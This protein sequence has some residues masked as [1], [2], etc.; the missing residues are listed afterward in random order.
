MRADDSGTQAEGSGTWAE[1]SGSICWILALENRWLAQ[2]LPGLRL[3]TR[4]CHFEWR[5]DSRG[6]VR[7]TEAA[8]EVVTH[9]R[10][11]EGVLDS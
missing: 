10:S 2:T 7:M 6:E 8:G 3:R 11:A 1:G 5:L 4:R 9:P